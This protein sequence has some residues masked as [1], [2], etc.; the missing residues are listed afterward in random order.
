M[1]LFVSLLHLWVFPFKSMG[2]GI[3]FY[4]KG[5]V[6]IPSKIERLRKET[7][8]D[9]VISKNKNVAS[10]VLGVVVVGGE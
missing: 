3:P 7:L 8:V 1:T 5:K 2:P 10:R 9:T 4:V 6:K